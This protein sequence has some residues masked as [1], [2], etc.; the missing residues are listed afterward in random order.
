MSIT[1]KIVI[2]YF[3]F[4]YTSLLV[5]YDYSVYNKGDGLMSK[6]T[7]DELWK[8]IAKLALEITVSNANCT[9]IGTIHQPKL[10]KIVKKLR[11]F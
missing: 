9:C 4:L 10:P 2:Y 8:T 11:K 1:A 5:L 3:K 7:T 6:R